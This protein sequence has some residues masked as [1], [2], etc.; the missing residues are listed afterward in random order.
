M[1]QF[2]LTTAMGKRLIG[3]AMAV[4]PEIRKVLKKG[5]LVIIAGSTNGYVAE[6]ILTD[7]GQAD[8]FSRIGF[9]RGLTAAPGANP[10]KAV[11]PG[12]IIIVD[13]TWQ[14][15][16][17]TIQD[18]A[19]DLKTGDVILKGANAFDP[20]GRP[21][22]QIGDLKGGTLFFAL[23][24]VIGRRVR[25]IMPVGL[26]KRV[27]EDV[28]VLAARCNAPGSEG[29]RLCP[30]PASIFTKLDT[31]RLLTDAEACLLAAG[32][33]YGA[34]GSLWLGIE[35]TL[36]QV[37]AAIELIRSLTGEMPCRV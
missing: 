7:L 32:G 19:D 3:K 37:N 23:P 21:A 8:G 12:D 35:G 13:G 29:P 17:K 9:R 6:E 16:G 26:E 10:A 5:T 34:E 30:V 15:K 20:Q 22:V 36:D 24:T 28:N 11:F 31:I 2:C 33:V 27:M 18:I 1:K 4:H 25:L 14:H